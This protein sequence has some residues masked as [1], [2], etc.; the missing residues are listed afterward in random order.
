[1]KLLVIGFVALACMGTTKVEA[2]LYLPDA[3]E[4]VMEP[5]EQRRRIGNI[6]LLNK[7]E[8]KAEKEQPVKKIRT[9]LN[10]EHLAKFDSSMISRF[11][12]GSEKK[13]YLNLEKH[14]FA[15]ISKPP[16]K[17]SGEGEINQLIR[18][19]DSYGIPGGIF[20]LILLFAGIRYSMQYP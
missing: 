8:K 16:E 15:N 13:P 20:A 4:M 1:M 14:V 17:S 12:N 10:K 3:K 11:F 7:K 5:L 2:K 6:D 19:F 9:I 18:F